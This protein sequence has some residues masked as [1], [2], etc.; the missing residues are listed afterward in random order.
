ME[1]VLSKGSADY[2]LTA[3]LTGLIMLM[4]LGKGLGS[5]T[6][7]FIA[8]RGLEKHLEQARRCLDKYSERILEPLD[9]GVNQLG[10]RGEVTIDDLPVEWQIID[11]GPKT[12]DRYRGMLEKAATIFVNGPAGV[13]EKTI[14]S[15]GTKE[16]WE[17]ITRSKGYSVIGGGDTVASASR[18]SNLSRIGHVS[19]GGGALVR[20]LAGIELPLVRAMKKACQRWR[21]SVTALLR[22]TDYGES[23]E[24]ILDGRS[25]TVDEGAGK[26]E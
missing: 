13:Y 12:V 10:K 25:V 22:E 4:A 17:V 6:E 20:F 2:V 19:M 7:R 5:P 9:F 18:F 21:D 3:G 1:T 14:G 24:G 16:L 26:T 11:I 8:D 23:Q 15:Y